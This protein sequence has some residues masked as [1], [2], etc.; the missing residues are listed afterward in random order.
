MSLPSKL[1]GVIKAK[2][3]KEYTVEMNLLTPYTLQTNPPIHG[4]TWCSHNEFKPIIRPMSALTEPCV[5]ADYNGGETF[6]PV[7]EI[8]GNINQFEVECAVHILSSM[9]KMSA[10]NLQQLI[11]WHFWPNMPENEQIVYV[12]EEFNPYK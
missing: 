3:G 2:N 10:S 9:N 5:Q 4:Y 1:K 11:K 6:I 8:F 12:T 7:Y